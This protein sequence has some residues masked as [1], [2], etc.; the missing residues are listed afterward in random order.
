MIRSERCDHKQS[1]RESSTDHKQLEDR[2]REGL[3]PHPAGLLLTSARIAASWLAMSL[4]LLVLSS[5]RLRPIVPT[6][7]PDQLSNAACEQ[8]E[9]KGERKLSKKLRQK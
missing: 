9:Q 4:A 6:R 3:A 2:D 1:V 5:A 8:R 7:P